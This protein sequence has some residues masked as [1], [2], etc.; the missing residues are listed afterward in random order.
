MFSDLRNTFDYYIRSYTK[1][2]RKNYN[3]QIKNTESDYVFDILNEYFE[4]EFQD[5]I[6]ILD[7]GSKNWAYVR[8]EYN[9]FSQ[10]GKNLK[11][12][13]VE[14]DAYRL[15]SNL[16]SR[17]EVAKFYIK[18]LDGVNYIPDDVLNIQTK[19]DYIIWL[20]PFVT[21]YPLKKWGLPEKYFMPERLL[22]HAYSILDKKMLIINQGEEEAEIQKTL[23]DK[24]GICYTFL[25]EIVADKTIFKNK[26]YGYLIKKI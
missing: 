18:D 9:F 7:I 13:G 23:L 14:I 8:G 11:L 3:G 6:S 2:S 21:I 20:L 24:A 25:G 12:D 15:Y 22:E 16:Y 19:Y 26:R 17:Y 4:I 10:Y 1:F 5:N